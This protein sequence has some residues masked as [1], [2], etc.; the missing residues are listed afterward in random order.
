M[1][2]GV[3]TKDSGSRDAASE[4]PRLLLG[5]LAAFAAYFAMYAFR[6][7]LAVAGWSDVAFH[8]F[9]LDYKTALVIVQ[10]VGYAASKLVGIRVMAG[11]GRAGRA[12][13]IF[14][15]IFGAWACL[16]A[17][18]MLPP[19]LGLACI[20][21][22]GFALGMIWGLVFSYLEGRRITELL[23]A[24][25]CGAFILASGVVKSVGALLLQA[26]VPEH[27][28]PAATGLAFFPLL[29][30]SLWQLER[31]P[32][33]TAADEAE[34]TP[35]RPMGKAERAA[36][37]KAHGLPLALLSASYVVLTA[38]RDFRDNFAAE[39]WAALGQGGS[40]SVFTA[41]ELPVAVMALAGL[42][43]LII[44]RDNLRAMLAMHGVVMLGGV[45][46]G[47]GT[48]AFQ[49][50]LLGAM[51]WM[52][53]TGAGL[54]LAYL[55]FNAMLFDRMIA[56][57]GRPA[58]AG[59][60]IYIADTAGYAGSIALLMWRS[61]FTPAADWVPVFVA[62]ANVAAIL[63]IG[64]TALSAFWFLQRTGQPREVPLV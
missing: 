3:L 41:S 46:L 12:S 49:A 21:G 22:N 48:L 62:C 17:F 54:Y 13:A 50:G 24:I 58:N 10:V 37:L 11:F 57:L 34:R 18:A 61:L 39:L 64:F 60:L 55:P 32:P 30:A 14:A 35:R 16:V 53:L 29:L 44:V 47:L 20:L 42:A 28:M 26:G 52:I 23:G 43:A 7:P 38:M 59:F 9:G 31:M 8:P 27:W 51:P 56:V 4:L 33:P 36:F 6:K 5:G 1:G 25:L 19:A 45:L 63:I 40:A 15:L 2:A